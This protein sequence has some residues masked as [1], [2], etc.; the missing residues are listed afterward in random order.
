[1]PTCA[2]T[3]GHP[4]PTGSLS[5]TILITNMGLLHITFQIHFFFCFLNKYTNTFMHP[6]SENF[7]RHISHSLFLYNT[8]PELQCHLAS[9]FMRKI[10]KR[11]IPKP[12]HIYSVHM[13]KCFRISGVRTNGCVLPS[14]LKPVSIHVKKLQNMDFTRKYPFTDP[15][16]CKIYVECATK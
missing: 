12:A 8:S 5:I 2:C 9:P 6:L 11:W 15:S 3:F 14:L 10:T 13:H 1:M 4:Y 7:I 16:K